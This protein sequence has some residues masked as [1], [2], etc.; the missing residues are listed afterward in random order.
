MNQR[1]TAINYGFSV[2]DK[3]THLKDQSLVGIVMEIDADF[4]QGGVTTC[5]VA[6]GAVDFE[7]A[8]NTPRDEQSIHWT[9][10]LVLAC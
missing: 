7:D 4:D 1:D 5:R 8:K 9:N 3:V 6:W 2:G 10:K